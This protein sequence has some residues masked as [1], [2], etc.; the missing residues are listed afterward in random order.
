MGTQL[1][2]QQA[3]DHGNVADAVGEK[4]PALADPRDQHTGD[5]RADHAR[6]VEHGGVQRDRVHQV[7]AADHVDQKRLSR[8]NIKGVDDAQQR[9]EHD[10]LPHTHDVRE[11]K[12][13][14]NERENHRRGLGRDH[15]A[16]A[17]PTVSDHSADGASRNTGIWPAKPTTP[18]SSDEPVRR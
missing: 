11:R 1:H 3:R 6:A 12:N 2:Q 15:H 10:D 13:R 4:T 17:V 7:F 16:M 9:R 18:R 5:G 14:Q 8:G